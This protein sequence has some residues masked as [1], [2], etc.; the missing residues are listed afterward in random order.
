MCFPLI[1]GMM[2]CRP[3]S[4]QIAGIF[5][6]LQC[7]AMPS[8]N[9]DLDFFTHKKIRRFS[10]EAG[11]GSEVFLIRLWVYV[12]KHYPEDGGCN[13][14]LPEEVE[15]ACGSSTPI[16]DIL[17][18]HRLID[19]WGN[20]FRVHNWEK[21][22]SHL[23]LYRD[24]KEECR[25]KTRLRVTRHREKKRCN[26]DVT[27]DVTHHVTPV[28][29]CNETPMQ[30]NAVQCNTETD[31]S[32]SREEVFSD[33]LCNLAREIIGLTPE[34]ILTGWTTV[35]K[36][37]EEWITEALQIASEGGKRGNGAAQYAAGIMRGW[38][39]DGKPERIEG[40]KR[41]NGKRNGKVGGIART[42]YDAQYEGLD[43]WKDAPV[44][45]G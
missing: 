33:T 31:L 21:H 34:G 19:V 28:T 4:R 6:E 11:E 43:D 12:G 3:R 24:R 45:N 32:V 1:T 29:Q 9:I 20:G 42:E 23:I 8:L 27:H 7:A 40:V 35:Q 41:N 37:T 25:E 36:W 14:W 39:R 2:C 17:V 5:L 22:A 26:A 44:E 38:T 16:C 13:D 30:C 15:E 10:K 18:K